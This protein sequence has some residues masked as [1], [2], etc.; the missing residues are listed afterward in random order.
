MVIVT[1]D[2]LFILLV[3][4][5]VIHC[6]CWNVHTKC[7]SRVTTLCPMAKT[8]CMSTPQ[9]L[10]SWHGNGIWGSCG[11]IA[12]SRVCHSL[13][14]KREG[15]W[16][17]LYIIVSITACQQ[18]DYWGTLYALYLKYD[19]QILIISVKLLPVSISGGKFSS[20]HAPRPSSMSKLWML[21]VLSTLHTMKASPTVCLTLS[22]T[23]NSAAMMILMIYERSNLKPKPA[24]H[25]LNYF[26]IRSWLVWV[27]FL[28]L[29]ILECPNIHTYM[30]GIQQSCNPT[31]M[32]SPIMFA[33][34]YVWCQ[35]WYFI[36][37]MYKISY[38]ILKVVPYSFWYYNLL[39]N[40]YGIG[41]CM[42]MF[43]TLQPENGVVIPKGFFMRLSVLRVFCWYIIALTNK[44]KLYMCTTHTGHS[45][46][47]DDRN[48]NC[49]NMQLC[50]YCN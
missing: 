40:K 25:P 11:G 3:Y 22:P 21:S 18:C 47:V 1:S 8:P 7:S 49:K 26:W 29:R 24:T 10:M 14:L 41:A 16:V 46:L 50:R 42:H 44:R 38:H 19:S 28:P 36:M 48:W 20:K 39:T 45:I 5:I 9:R 6:F 37:P 35:V 4:Q 31:Y 27:E 30:S 23:L 12:T 32:Y 13:K 15:Q 2:V 43:S 34:T 17:V 33:H